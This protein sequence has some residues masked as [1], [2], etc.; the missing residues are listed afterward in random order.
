MGGI[1]L[2]FSVLVWVADYFPRPA[3]PAADAPVA[4]QTAATESY[5]CRMG[6]AI[7]PVFAPLGFDWKMSV[8]ILSGVGAKELV[9]S[10]LGVM[11]ADETSGIDTD[12]E[13]QIMHHLQKQLLETTTPAAAMAYLVFVLLYFPCIATIVAIRHESGRWKWALLTAVYTTVLAYVCAWITFQLM[14]L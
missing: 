5:L 12:D 14:Q 8:G 4:E 1:I 10:T 3:E 13:E 11:Y 2:A 6:R 9:V 7:E